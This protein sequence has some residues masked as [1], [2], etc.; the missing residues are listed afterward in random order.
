MFVIQDYSGCYLAEGLKSRGTQGGVARVMSEEVGRALRFD[1]AW[2]AAAALARE[3]DEG[4]IR[5]YSPRVV[6]I[7]EDLDA[8][9][10]LPTDL[11]KARP[12]LLEP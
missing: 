5:Y 6:A 11:S 9:I 4:E 10:N 3:Y 8:P 12:E 7:G 1:E 2:V